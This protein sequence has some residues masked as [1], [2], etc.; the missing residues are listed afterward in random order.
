[1][2]FINRCYSKSVKTGAILALSVFCLSAN[3]AQETFTSPVDKSAGGVSDYISA[4]FV[5]DCQKPGGKGDNF[6]DMYCSKQELVISTKMSDGKTMKEVWNGLGV[7]KNPDGT[8]SHNI[9]TVSVIEVPDG[10]D[11]DLYYYITLTAAK[12]DDEGRGPNIYALLLDSNLKKIIKSHM[13]T[14]DTSLSQWFTDVNRKAKKSGE[15][16]SETLIIEAY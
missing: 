4:K 3:S 5:R 9:Q 6:S 12:N 16:V 14:K 11:S 2:N 13:K 1:M 15:K 7:A 10:G 8:L